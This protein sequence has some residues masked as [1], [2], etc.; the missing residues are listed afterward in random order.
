MGR[1]ASIQALRMIKA[2]MRLGWMVARV[3]GSHYV[4]TMEGRP[5]IPIPVH[6]GRTLKE[7]TARSI[8]AK[9]IALWV[10]SAERDGATGRGS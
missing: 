5:R 6:R 9:A 2:L 8:L 7:G 3:T 1:M 4:M 10:A